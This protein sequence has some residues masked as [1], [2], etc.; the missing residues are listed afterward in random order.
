MDQVQ[1]EVVN[2]PVLELFLGN[3]LDLLVVVEC[4]PKLGDNKEL[5]TLYESVFDGAGNTL[6][7]FYFIAVI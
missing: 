6:A 2:A 3:G 7:G 1:V 5:F 4:L